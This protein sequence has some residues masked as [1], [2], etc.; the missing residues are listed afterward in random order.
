M[1]PVSLSKI[2]SHCCKIHVS[3]H[4]TSNLWA[5]Y[6]RLFNHRNGWGIFGGQSNTRWILT[7]PMQLTDVYCWVIGDSNAFR[8]LWTHSCT[9]C[10]MYE[11]PRDK[12]RRLSWYRLSVG[13]LTYF[14]SP[15]LQLCLT[16]TQRDGEQNAESRRDNSHRESHVL[17]A[18]SH[19]EKIVSK[20]NIA[21][22]DIAWATIK[23]KGLYPLRRHILWGIPIINL[24]RSLDR[25]RHV[26]GIPIPVRHILVNRGLVLNLFN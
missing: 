11:F 2:I 8:I 14:I 7:V 16:H 20:V 22:G 19:L 9:I 10:R 25:L 5:G 15:A 12:R 13:H 6:S 18:W 17:H 26:M 23:L 4:F 24:R 21:L 1:H 3:Y